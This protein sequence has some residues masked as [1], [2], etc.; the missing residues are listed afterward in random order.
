MKE[1]GREGVRKRKEGREGRKN[2]EKG[3]TKGKMRERKRRKG[4]VSGITYNLHNI[5]HW[6]NSIMHNYPHFI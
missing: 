1:G 2:K 5:M 3:V 4:R 6:A